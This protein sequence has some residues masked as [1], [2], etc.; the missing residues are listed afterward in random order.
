MVRPAEIDAKRR[1]M[2]QLWKHASTIELV[3]V[4]EAGLAERDRMAL[5]VARVVNSAKAAELSDEAIAPV[6]GAAADV[7]AMMDEDLAILKR[8]LRQRRDEQ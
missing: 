2:H 3:K 5:H 6:M 7:L 1:Q 4:F 8:L